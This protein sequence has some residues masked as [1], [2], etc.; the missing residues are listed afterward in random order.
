VLTGDWILA[1]PSAL[2][3]AALAAWF[4]FKKRDG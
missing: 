4:M 1:I 3:L 2:L